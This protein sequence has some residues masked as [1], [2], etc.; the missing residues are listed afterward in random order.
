MSRARG[1][2]LR[3]AF[4]D[5]PVVIGRVCSAHA[6]VLP[7]NA[8]ICTGA[9]QS[10]V[11]HMQPVCL[12][13]A[14][15]RKASQLHAAAAAR[16][17]NNATQATDAVTRLYAALNARDAAAISGCLAADVAYENL[18]IADS[19]A[20]NTAVTSFFVESLAAVPREA[21]FEL[22]TVAG[23]ASS[24]VTVVWRLV[25]PSSQALLSRG[26]ALYTLQPGS[27]C[28][29]AV[30][31]CHEH[32]V[33]LSYSQLL[34][35]RP[36][37]AGLAGPLPAVLPG[38]QEVSRGLQQEGSGAA[39]SAAAAAAAAEPED[40]SG[41][42]VKDAARSD[43]SGYEA[44][45]DVLGLSGMQKVTARLIEGVEI[46]QTSS[47]F[48]VSF[49]T[50]VPFFKV[51]EEVPLNSG[52]TQQW[53][54]DLRQGQQSAAARTVASAEQ[55]GVLVEMAWGAPLAGTLTELYSLLPDGSMTVT[56]ETRIGSKQAKA[57]GAGSYAKGAFLFQ[58]L[59]WYQRTKRG[60]GG[61]REAMF[62]D[63]RRRNGS[64]GDVLRRQQGQGLS[65]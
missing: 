4:F 3:S 54:R 47:K 59:C 64:V 52:S 21:A 27:G 11:L 60:N 33:K 56:A 46:Q 41:L 61:S 58:E 39:G 35:V 38:L 13:Q 44:M 17:D 37:V 34:L 26:I 14:G 32:P 15:R 31:E 45:L 19:L 62:A 40:F 29:A 22:E 1:K 43:L 25:L 63:S 24:A 8:Q 50:V 12:H 18:A 28:I 5:T 36:L 57:P 16:P 49:V 51:T 23:A 6:A 53:R 48:T 42:W 65:V 20:G 2:G 30:T 9:R 55:R 10:L 7:A